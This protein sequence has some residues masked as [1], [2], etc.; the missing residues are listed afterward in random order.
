MHEENT[1]MHK[2]KNTSECGFEPL[3]DSQDLAHLMGVHPETVKR[4]ARTGE[5]PRIKVG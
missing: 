5:I 4:R 1:T 3:P 2:D